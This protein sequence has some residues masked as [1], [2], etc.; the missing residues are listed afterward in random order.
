MCSFRVTAELESVLGSDQNPAAAPG[1]RS[2]H[3]WGPFPGRFLTVGRE[4]P[5][6]PP[7]LFPL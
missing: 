2:A 5:R 7:R 4:A 3:A 1:L 6:L